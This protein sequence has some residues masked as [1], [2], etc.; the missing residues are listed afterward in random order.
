VSQL[1]FDVHAT[2]IY[3]KGAGNVCESIL[4]TLS[5]EFPGYVGTVHVGE[6]SRLAE[7]SGK[8][9]NLEVSVRGRFLFNN[10]SRV[11]ECIFWDLIHRGK[12]PIFV[13]G[14]IPLRTKNKQFLLVQNSLFAFDRNR[15]RFLGW[16]VLAQKMLF[17]LNQKFVSIYVYQTQVQREHFE[18]IF[19]FLIGRGVVFG[20]GL[21]TFYD[22][23]YVRAWNPRSKVHD[24]LILFYPADFYWH[25]N[26]A[27][28]GSIP[29]VQK[30]WPIERLILTIDRKNN[31]S[32]TTDWIQCVGEM[33]RSEIM[34]NYTSCSA[35]L[36]LAKTESLGLPLLES[37][38]VGCP[39]IC[40]DL[41]YCRSILGDE[42]IYFDEDNIYSLH[43][44]ILE[45][46]QRLSQQSEP[47]YVS[48]VAPDNGRWRRKTLE[49]IKTFESVVA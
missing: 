47:F 3:G 5:T 34:Q 17:R 2:N 48:N 6:G 23:S 8:W 42:A 49:I 39:I 32:P 33:T 20:H 25:K 36:Y 12:R 46:S 41:D 38:M 19:P 45:C 22:S 43:R 40:P 28:L 9:L 16:R 27:L 11:V 4:T 37:K 21:P 26:H 14:D 15:G 29:R 1:C 10:L 24:R 13:L 7:T 30:S 44:A 31:P 35:V 18:S